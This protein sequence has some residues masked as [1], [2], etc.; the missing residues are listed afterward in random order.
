MRLEGVMLLAAPTS[1]SQAYLQALVTHDLHPERVVLMGD[2]LSQ[3]CGRALDARAW[4]GIGLPDLG[5][6]LEATCARAA[7]PFTMC[8]TEDVNDERVTAAIGTAA[9]RLVIYSGYG[10]QIVGNRVLDCGPRFLHLHSGWLPEYR[11]STT[12]YYALL[13][14]EDPGVTAI[15]LDRDIDTGPIV[16]R[17]RYPRPPVGLDIDNVYDAAIRADLLVRVMSDYREAGGLRQQES[18]R[19]EEGSTYYVIHP[20]LKHLAI[21]SVGGGHP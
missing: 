20:V 5:E 10:G 16:A 14:G 15:L 21:L 6:S 9:P 17:R 1:R 18:Q 2:G 19:P 8:T 3:S 11:G 7:I 13:N 4:N 12:I